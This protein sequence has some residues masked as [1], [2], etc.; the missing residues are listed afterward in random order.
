M[1]FRCT[2]IDTDLSVFKSSNEIDDNLRVTVQQLC[3]EKYSAFVLNRKIKI[4]FSHKI[5]RTIHFSDTCY[6]Q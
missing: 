4:K 6:K 3:F 2:K 5:K 1:T